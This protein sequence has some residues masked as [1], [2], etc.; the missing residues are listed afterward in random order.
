MSIAE[1]FVTDCP[2][3]IKEALGVVRQLGGRIISEEGAGLGTQ[4][5]YTVVFEDG[6]KAVLNEELAWGYASA[7]A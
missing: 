2:P 7:E 5:E 4:R 1:N 6:S 3:F